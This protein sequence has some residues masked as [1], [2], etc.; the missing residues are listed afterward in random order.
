MTDSQLA[1]QHT[2][3][4]LDLQGFKDG[5]TTLP[6]LELVNVH[7]ADLEN[8][9]DHLKMVEENGMVEDA[10]HAF[11]SNSALIS[12]LGNLTLQDGPQEQ[13]E[14]ANAAEGEEEEKGEQVNAAAKA[15]SSAGRKVR[16]S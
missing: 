2:T 11:D 12:Q 8:Y 1:S 6:C 14:G 7:N 9:D 13:Q 4:L 3:A 5:S 10:K 15:G 16:G